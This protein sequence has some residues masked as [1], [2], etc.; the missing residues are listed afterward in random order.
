M[1]LNPV[2]VLCGAAL[3]APSVHAQVSAQYRPHY[4]RVQFQIQSLRSAAVPGANQQ[5]L[6]SGVSALSTSIQGLPPVGP[7][8]TPADYAAN[9]QLVR[10]AYSTLGAVEALPGNSP[11]LRSSLAGA[12]GTLG[13]FQ[14]RPEFKGHGFNPVRAYGRASGLTRGVMLSS[15][16]NDRMAE[17]SLERYAMSMATYNLVNGR[18]WDSMYGGS[19]RPQEEPYDFNVQPSVERLPVPVPEIDASSLNAQDRAAWDELRSQFI[20]ASAKITEALR[21]LD[22]LSARLR[23]RGMDVNAGDLATSYRMQGF[24]EDSATL[25]RQKDFANGKLML[26]RAEYERKRLRPVTGQ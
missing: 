7:S 22:G 20:V 8:A 15:G 4:D 16:F 25:I 24:L 18:I 21:N 3:A 26:E 5:Q 1:R 11:A 2:L 10:D 9:Q 14:A 23:Q 12:Y 6:A 17:R 19:Q 13:D